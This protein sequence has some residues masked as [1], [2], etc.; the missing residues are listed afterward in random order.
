MIALLALLGAAIG[1]FLNVVIDRVPAGESL[2]E[3]P[4]HCPSCGRTLGVR[5]LVPVFSYVALRGRCR[6]C[7]APIPWRVPAV[8]VATALLF[9][10]LW[11]AVPPASP[12]DALWLAAAA[13]YTCVMVVLFVIDLERR[14]VPNVIVLPAIALALAMAPILAWLAPRYAHHGLL[15]LLAP[16]GAAGV[17][18]LALTGQVAGGVAAFGIFWLIWRVAPQGMG[19]GDVKLA[20]FA[21]LITGFPGALA[22]VF[23]SFI[24]GGTVGA[25]LL[26]GGR[27]ARKTAI[28]FA[29]FLIVT[30]FVT[31]VFG[32]ELLAWYLG[33]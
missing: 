3:P 24:I 2:L 9:A 12:G 26:V 31:M 22:A 11:R 33:R 25:A 7:R 16:P 1:S 28:P 13:I 17:S 5:D 30:T 4:S 15:E 29:P 18:P 6:T 14:R 10:F 27:A 20:G 19:A 32:D 21:G 8:E 23:G